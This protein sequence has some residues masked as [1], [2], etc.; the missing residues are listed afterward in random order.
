MYI[1]IHIWTICTCTHVVVCPLFPLLSCCQSVVIWH[2]GHSPLCS[3]DKRLQ[4]ETI[5]THLVSLPNIYY[6]MQVCVHCPLC[7]CVCVYMYMYYACVCL[8]C[9]IIVFIL[10]MHIVCVYIVASCTVCWS[11]EWFEW[12]IGLTLKM[13]P[14]KHD[15]YHLHILMRLS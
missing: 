12:I 1:C 10:D 7:V 15:V 5:T 6:T 9:Y 14:Y 3:H 11:L 13:D 2:I 8:Y 4:S